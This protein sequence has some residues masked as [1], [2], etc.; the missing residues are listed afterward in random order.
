MLRPCLCNSSDNTKL[1]LHNTSYVSYRLAQSRI[2]PAL[3]YKVNFVYVFLN[4]IQLKGHKPLHNSCLPITENAYLRQTGPGGRG[5]GEQQEEEV[6]C[7]QPTLQVKIIGNLRRVSNTHSLIDVVG[8]LLLQDGIFQF[9][10]HK[11]L[12]STPTWLEK[13]EAQKRRAGLLPL[14]LLLQRASFC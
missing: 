12:S 1:P 7:D 9:S 6:C 4:S 5:D 2:L 14:N 11:C 13:K 8:A 3:K 10:L